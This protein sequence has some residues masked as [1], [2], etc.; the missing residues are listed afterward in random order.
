[1]MCFLILFIFSVL[2]EPFPG[3]IFNILPNFIIILLIADHMVII[4]ALPD[5]FAVFLVA[6]PFECPNESGDHRCPRRDTPPGVSVCNYFPRRDTP[7]WV[8]V[9]FVDGNEKM[10]MIRHD[11][12]LIHG[13]IIIKSVH[14]PDVLLSDP[15]V[16]QQFPVRFLGTPGDGCP[17]GYFRKDLLS[18]LGADRYKIR[19]VPAV[20]KSPNTVV[21]SIW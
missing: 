1:M 10:D 14:L 19:S 2:H 13:Y 4:P 15:S 18:L 20:I 6:K 9:C 3:I 12:I 5:I 16:G 8:S 17:Y 11:H 21:F 7:P